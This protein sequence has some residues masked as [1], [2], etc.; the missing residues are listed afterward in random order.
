MTNITVKEPLARGLLMLCIYL[1]PLLF[2]SFLYFLIVFIAD[3]NTKVV[4]NKTQYAHI[5]SPNNRSTVSE[6]FEI[7]GSTEVPKTEHT[8]Y[9]IESRNKLFWPKYNL[10]KQKKTWKKQLVHRAG[11]NQFASYKVIMAD[12]S[13]SGTI[14]DWFKTS[15][16]TGKY[17]GM[18]EIPL[19]SVVA[20]IRVKTQ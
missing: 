16:Q 2:A 18:S 4:S 10:G 19:S 3:I 12:K 17:P 8:Y 7:T 15:Q 11:K 20:N 1:F 13:L 9:L 14:E 6:K 5:Q